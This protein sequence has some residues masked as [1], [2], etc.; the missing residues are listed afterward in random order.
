[1]VHLVVSSEVFESVD[2]LFHLHQMNIEEREA[3][4]KNV[5]IINCA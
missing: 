3:K 1:M 5:K 2:I 4:F